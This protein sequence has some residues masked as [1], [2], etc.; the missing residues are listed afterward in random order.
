MTK[1]PGIEGLHSFPSLKALKSG[2]NEAKL[3]T[4][5]FGYR[6]PYIVESLNLI[7]QKGGEQ[8]I[9]DLRGKPIAHVRSELTTLKGV[10]RKVA[11]CVA[12]F[13]MDCADTIPVDTHVF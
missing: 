3:R 8:W 10:G 6:A 11:D 4:L 1:S 13:S 12:L 5:G 2:A 7:E 9:R